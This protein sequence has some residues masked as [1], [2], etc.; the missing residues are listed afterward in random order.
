MT[1]LT[2]SLLELV[3]FT[4]NP[5]ALLSYLAFVTNSVVIYLIISKGSKDTINRWFIF[6]VLA[7]L[8]WS[9]SETLSRLSVTTTAAG[10]WETVGIIG[11]V[12]VSPLF[13][14]FT[15]AYIG[16][17]NVLS[18]FST[19]ALLFLPA[20]F[21]LFLGWTTDLVNVNTPSSYHRVFWGWESPTA[22]LFWLAIAWLDF[23]FVISIGLLARY[24]L[25]LKNKKRRTQ[26][27][28]IIFGVLVPVVGGSITNGLLPILHIQIFQAAVMLTTVMSIT[29]TY[30]MIRYKLF[31]IN[32]ATAV[33]NIVDTMHEILI[34]FNLDG[35][36]EFVNP[37][38]KDVLGYEKED[39]VGSHLNRL[40]KGNWQLFSEKYL[41][42]L[43]EGQ[44]I[45][46]AELDLIA[47]DG[48][49]KPVNFS[50]SVLKDSNGVIY[51]V[52]GVA[53]DISKIR[54]LF[55]DITAERNKLNTTIESIADG[56]L[57]IDFE[58]NVITINPAALKMLGFSESDIVG[59]NID[60]LV[61]ASE[62]DKSIW[63]KD[64]IPHRKL[65]S[66]EIVYQKDNLKIITDYNKQLYVNL[67]ASA[68][69]EGEDVGLGAIITL[70][71]VSKEKE[72]EEMKLDFVSM[73][74]HELRTP[75][76]A[77]RGYLS[78]LQEEVKKSLPKEQ[79]SFLDK[80]FISSSQL[81]A[82]VE[83]LLSVSRIERGAMKI[84]AVAQ[85][86]KSLLQELVSNYVP[87][88]KE[89]G[90]NLSL[91]C[92]A[93]LPPVLVDKFRISE[94]VSNLLGNALNYTKAGGSVEI[95]SQYDPKAGKVATTLTDTGQ[96]IPASAL[97]HL[98]TKFFRVSGVLEQGSKGTGLGLYISKA[99]V[100]MH[101]GDIWVDSTLGKGSRFSFTIPVATRPALDKETPNNYSKPKR[102]FNRKKVKL[103]VEV[104]G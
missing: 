49:K 15:L 45:T 71:D 54:A 30:A 67:T 10:F 52:V 81:A 6:T 24:W 28:L 2:A 80:A 13:L 94:V 51:G 69:R 91:N 92:S 16:K 53:T 25:R 42:T 48:T 63:F 35:I 58:G 14:S 19:L 90:I 33:I 85:N 36:I 1:N 57:A 46:G 78:V 8:P 87:L 74:A 60:N 62:D 88:S 104:S 22:P 83:N 89:K 100:N 39:L 96:G 32:P 7:L 76:T 84:E 61:K 18:K 73:A 64:F 38:V 21:F 44:T 65:E 101:G 70:N 75:L 17:D 97:P 82:L 86:W 41:K 55:T 20:V 43:Y 95:S 72:L 40:F 66:D 68:I 102:T 56:V 59:K 29:I 103:A 5:Y 47:A 26:T 27:A 99:I 34:V 31:V 77:I 37:A 93:D 79:R 4:F 98:F 23:L 9:L 12:F 3:N 11:W 50:A